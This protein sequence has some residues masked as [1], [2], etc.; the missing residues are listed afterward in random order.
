MVEKKKK[1]E[2]IE[3]LSSQVP[4]T[5]RLPRA[6]GDHISDLALLC[7]ERWLGIE[8]IDLMLEVL[9]D[10]LELDSNGTR[11]SIQGVQFMW[12]LIETYRY[13]RNTYA[14]A[15]SCKFL[16]ECAANLKTA[17]VSV[18]GTVIAVMI[19]RD[20]V[21][22]PRGEEIRANHWCAVAINT[23][24]LTIQ[25][26]DPMG[27]LPPSELLDVIHWWLDLSFSTTLSLGE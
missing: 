9:K 17:K 2:A 12:K 6:M 26:G 25:Y 5:Y 23:D 24:Q 4:W 14:E 27:K 20:D 10:Q 22:L 1:I 18:I 21:L 16:R 8:H 15:Q 3:L 11:A 19:G 7:S 13:S